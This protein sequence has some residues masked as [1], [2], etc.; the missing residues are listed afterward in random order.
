MS[1]VRHQK[2]LEIVRQQG[3]ASI[4]FLA[5]Q[6]S[7]SQPTIR[8]DLKKL[9]EDNLLQ[10]FHGGVT[11]ADN[12]VRLGYRF[13]SEIMNDAKSRIAATAIQYMDRVESCFID[14]GTT[15]DQVASAMAVLERRQIITHNLSAAMTFAALGSK[16]NVIVTGGTLHGADGSLTGVKTCEEIKGYFADIALIGASGLDESGAVLDYDVEKVAVKKAMMSSAACRILLLDS[17][18]FRKRGALKIANLSEFDL[19][20]TDV[21]PEPA[22]E[23]LFQQ[24]GTKLIIA[25]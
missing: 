3:Y 25:Q 2:L 19:C 7:C 5:A 6:L 10:R 20:I 21:S 15:C 22:Y 18:K 9:C 24:S 16:H 1:Q 8:R 13:K 14:I 4:E 11:E 23:T 17:S 12:N